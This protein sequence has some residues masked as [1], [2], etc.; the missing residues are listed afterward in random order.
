[1]LNRFVV[2]ARLAR[3]RFLGSLKGLQI[4]SQ[5]YG[6]YALDFGNVELCRIRTLVR[7]TTIESS[8]TVLTFYNSFS[9]FSLCRAFLAAP[10]PVS[11]FQHTE[12]IP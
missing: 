7:L 1:M 12:M 6:T 10:A 2:S 4:R 3:S 11:A 5:K 9:S 8:E